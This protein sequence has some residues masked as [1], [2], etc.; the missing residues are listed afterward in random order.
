LRIIVMAGFEEILNGRLEKTRRHS[1]RS[2]PLTS[3]HV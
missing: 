1:L 2:R 3:S